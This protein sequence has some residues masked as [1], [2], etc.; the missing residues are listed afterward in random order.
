MRADPRDRITQTAF[1]IAPSLLGVR[2]ASPARRAG[3]LGVDLL[4][5]VVVTEGGGAVAAGLLAAVLFVL[6]AMRSPSKTRLRRIGR[7][8][9]VGVGALILFGVATGVVDDALDDDEDSTEAATLYSGDP[10][11]GGDPISESVE[12]QLADAGIDVERGGESPADT[13]AGVATLRAYAS[14]LDAGD[15][16]AADSLSPAATAFLA[17]D[18]LAGL[19]TRLD[20]AR[21]R[22]R[23]V[24]DERDGLRET[25]DRP[26]IRRTAL[27]FAADFGLIIGWIGVYLTLTLAVWNGYTP[28]K[29]LFGIRVVRLDGRRVGLWTAFE[30]FGGYAAGLVT[31]LIGF[32]QILWDPNRQGVEDKVAGTAVVRMA[33]A[34]SPRRVGPPV[35]SAPQAG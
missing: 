12:R 7:A 5:A 34:R 9:L 21:D 4:L 15:R 24:E 33:N 26:S 13:A 22:L 23:E 16:A 29:R 1:E 6:A 11:F 25:L 31:G 20:R 28:G 14:A 18:E 10:A 32:A 17:G 3:A 8:A 35:A 30:R 19:R 2:L 27:A